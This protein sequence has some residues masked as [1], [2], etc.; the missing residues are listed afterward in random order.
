MPPCQGQV[1]SAVQP[2]AQV[3]P[4]QANSLL[5]ACAGHMPPEQF[6]RHR[7]ALHTRLRSITTTQS[8]PQIGNS[9][10]WWKI[11]RIAA[12]APAHSDCR[13]QKMKRIAVAAPAH[14]DSRPALNDQRPSWADCQSAI[15]QAASAHST[16]M[17]DRVT[18]SVQSAAAG[19]DHSS[20]AIATTTCRNKTVANLDHEALKRMCNARTA[21][22]PRNMRIALP[23]GLAW[24]MQHP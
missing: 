17:Q 5:S 18:V 9:W 1:Q 7:C 16:D 19:A 13:Q 23:D 21:R 3:H 20:S 2:G 24:L 6:R 22:R 11:K 15:T 10:R 4:I 12:A 14:S 8:R